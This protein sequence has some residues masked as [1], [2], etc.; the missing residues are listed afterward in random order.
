MEVAY[1]Y[2]RDKEEAPMKVGDTVKWYVELPHNDFAY[3]DY[4]FH[5]F[6][7][8]VVKIVGGFVKIKTPYKMITK[9]QDNLTIV[10]AHE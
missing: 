6:S 5:E 9:H 10:E 8:K 4:M 2:R 7:G 3:H 1:G